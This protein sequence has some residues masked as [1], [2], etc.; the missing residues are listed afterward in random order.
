M[1]LPTLSQRGFPLPAQCAPLDRL[2]PY[3]PNTIR[4]GITLINLNP[5]KPNSLNY[6][7]LLTIAY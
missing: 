7:S 1:R 2:S 3:Y 6:Q 5:T 4:P